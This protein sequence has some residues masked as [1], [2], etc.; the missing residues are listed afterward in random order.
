MMS[1][2]SAQAR[3]CEA[4]MYTHWGPLHRISPRLSPWTYGAGRRAVTVTEEDA[5]SMASA[6]LHRG[7]GGAAE[8]AEGGG[9]G[10]RGGDAERDPER[11]QVGVGLLQ[12]RR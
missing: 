11:P 6:R 12:H 3:S 1:N 8:G 5:S 9:G 7:G 4:G 10:P 2:V